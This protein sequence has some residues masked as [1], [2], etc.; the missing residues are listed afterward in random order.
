LANRRRELLKTTGDLS[1]QELLEQRAWYF[2]CGVNPR[3]VKQMF[4]KE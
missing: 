1:A 2:A 3:M 4:L